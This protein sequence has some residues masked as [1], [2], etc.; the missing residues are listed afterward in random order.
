MR[1]N[2]DLLHI[3]EAAFR[4]SAEPGLIQ[5]AQRCLIKWAQRTRQ[6]SRQEKKNQNLKFCLLPQFHSAV[7]TWTVL[8]P[9]ALAEYRKKKHGRGIHICFHL[10]YMI[11]KSLIWTNPSL[12]PHTVLFERSLNICTLGVN[13]I[14]KVN[15][16][17]GQ[18]WAQHILFLVWA[19]SS[20]LL[21]N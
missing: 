9:R 13:V 11:F 5:N 7:E 1:H 14:L 3:S 20:L 2:L 4:R 10:C 16:A 6:S 12:R 21:R 17:D 15:S 8:K 18:G 19:S